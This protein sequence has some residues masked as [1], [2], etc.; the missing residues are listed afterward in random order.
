MRWA[1]ATA[2]AQDPSPRFSTTPSGSFTAGTPSSSCIDNSM[3]FSVDEH[4]AAKPA[5]TSC[6][7]DQPQ[8][9]ADQE[10]RPPASC[11]EDLFRQCASQGAAAGS[12]QPSSFESMRA[13]ASRQLLRICSQGSLASGLDCSS[14]LLQQGTTSHA[15]AAGGGAAAGAAGTDRLMLRIGSQGSSATGFSGFECGPQVLV[16]EVSRHSRHNAAAV[17][18]HSTPLPLPSGGKGGRAGDM[19]WSDRQQVQQNGLRGAT[20][21]RKQ[22]WPL[23]VAAGLAGAAS[24][25]GSK[26]RPQLQTQQLS[27]SQDG[28]ANGW[29]G[30][31]DWLLQWSDARAGEAGSWQGGSSKSD[32]GQPPTCAGQTSLGACCGGSSRDSSPLGFETSLDLFLHGCCQ[33]AAGGHGAGSPGL[34]ALLQG[35][36]QGG[37]S[38]GG[39][40]SEGAAPF[41]SE[42]SLGPWLRGCSGDLEQQPQSASEGGM[43]GIPAPVLQRLLLAAAAAATL[44]DQL[45]YADRLQAPDPEAAA[46][47]SQDG[48]ARWLEETARRGA[49]CT[50][51]PA[52]CTDRSGAQLAQQTTCRGEA[53][54]HTSPATPERQ[55]QGHGSGQAA[56]AHG[57]QAAQQQAVLGKRAPRYHTDFICDAEFTEALEHL[58]HPACLIPC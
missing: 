51:S 36:G 52:G 11:I 20:G 56:A 1:P 48:I 33:G 43:V 29:A 39:M 32:L 21:G 7:T 41:K 9:W 34:D 6:L 49:A 2:A 47:S 17:H 15:A 8:Q 57:L 3:F 27:S 40:R 50:A 55:S 16:Q 58:S 23:P 10:E 22:G 18:L 42:A 24:R 35:C 14:Q 28:R 46:A 45:Q 53:A 13:D 37:M 12:Q 19:P 30:A 38:A 44:G 25:E 26:D 54:A 5:G 4:T 31:A